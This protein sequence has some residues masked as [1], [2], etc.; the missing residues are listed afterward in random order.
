MLS[1]EETSIAVVTKILGDQFFKAIYW[2]FQNIGKK[3]INTMKH[4]NKQCNL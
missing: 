1:M 3:L 2:S 4:Q